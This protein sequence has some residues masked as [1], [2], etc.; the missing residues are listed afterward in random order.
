MYENWFIF[1]LQIM[2]IKLLHYSS[3]KNE[4]CSF[5]QLQYFPAL[6]IY[7]EVHCLDKCLVKYDQAR[8]FTGESAFYCRVLFF[9]LSSL[10]D[11]FLS[12]LV[13]SGYKPK[14][15]GKDQK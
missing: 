7:I 8:E 5:S 15:T 13:F 9:Q 14:L 1:Y 12:V 4:L 3:E 6:I 11:T 10:N 2:I